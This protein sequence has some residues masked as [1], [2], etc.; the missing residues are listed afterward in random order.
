VAESSDHT[1]RSL[2][3]VGTVLITTG[4]LALTYGLIKTNTHSWTSPF[5]LGLLG[6]A[7]VLIGVW[8]WWESR[9]TDPMV[10]LG[11]FKI[12]QFAAAN[13]VGVLVGVALFGSLYFVTLYF[14]NIKGYSAQEAGIRSMPMTL[15]IMFVAPIAGRL[16][17]KIG[18][19]VPMTVGML[20]ATGGMLGLTQLTPTSSY[21]AMWP[22]FLLLGAG[23]SLTMPSL[24]GAAMSSVD[25]QKSG[26]ASGVVNSAR[27]VG[28]AVGIAVLGSVVAKL[29]ADQFGRAPEALQQLV[30][31]GQTKLIGQVAGPGT[32]AKAAEAF[33]H[34]M[35]G[36]MWVGAAL[37]FTAAMISL[38]ALRSGAAHAHAPA[39][40][41]QQA[42]VEL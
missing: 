31:G 3:I 1:S 16:N 25:P 30:V 26:V 4:L 13:A 36:A 14:Q 17:G 7:V 39:G 37:T 19:R 34:G 33:V 5:I 38:F 32:E 24:A 8:I 27:Q 21:N 42:A 29:A 9:T 10:P 18:P 22:F 41:Q 40:Q 2:D 20:L 23:I 28:G 35:T 12:R 11:F 15:V 6:T